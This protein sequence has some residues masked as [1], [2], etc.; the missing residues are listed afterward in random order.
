G[1]SGGSAYPRG[2]KPSVTARGVYGAGTRETRDDPKVE[3]ITSLAKRRL[4]MAVGVVTNTEVEDAPPAAMVAHPRRRS[5][6]DPIVQMF[7]ESKVDV[8]MGGGSAHF[9]PK[10]AAG[11]RRQDE[12]DYL[13]KFR[14]AGY[15]V[16]STD[17]ELKSAAADPATRK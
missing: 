13:A 10:S 14:G 6:Y 1:G 4:G 2:Q 17:R 15:A 7:Y 3:T 16:A 9:L 12:T 11:S 8:L 5:D